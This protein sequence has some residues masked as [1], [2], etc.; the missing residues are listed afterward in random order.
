MN[1]RAL[2]E[3]DLPLLRAIHAHHYSSEF[4]F[5]DF[6]SKFLC[7]FVVEDSDGTIVS[8]GGIRP[9]LESV[10]ITDLSKSVRIRRSA[11][12]NILSASNYFAKQGNF[13]QI[14]VFIQDQGWENHLR[15]IGFVPT[16]GNSLVLTI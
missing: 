14:H 1:I 16:K 13:D 15:K 8:A 7:C 12:M 2:K 5:P 11:L 3:S 9:I 6:V 10:L 4:E